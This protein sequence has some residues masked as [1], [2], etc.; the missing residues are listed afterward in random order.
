MN[1]E[2][3]RLTWYEGTPEASLARIAQADL[4][5]GA[6]IFDAG[7]GVSGLG[8]VLIQTGHSD[9]TVT[10]FSQSAGATEIRTETFIKQELL[11]LGEQFQA[12][13]YS[14]AVLKRLTALF[15]KVLLSMNSPLEWAIHRYGS[16]GTRTRD[17]W[18]DR[19]DPEGAPDGQISLFDAD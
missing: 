6:A 10:D 9:V 17:L 8:G 4:P 13:C 3:D 7:G 14:N 2:P 11:L 15:P 16:D 1:R 18:R 5:R 19:S 12:P